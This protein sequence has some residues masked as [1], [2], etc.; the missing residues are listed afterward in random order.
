MNNDDFWGNTNLTNVSIDTENSEEMMPGSHITEFHITKQKE[1]VTTELLNMV[2]NVPEVTCKY[3]ADGGHHNQSDSQSAKSADC[4]LNASKDESFFSNIIGNGDV[5]RV[6]RK[7]LNMME[8][9]ISDILP[10][11]SYLQAPTIVEDSHDTTDGNEMEDL[12][13]TAVNKITTIVWNVPTLYWNPTTSLVP[14]S[15]KKWKNGFTNGL[16]TM[17]YEIVT[18]TRLQNELKW[19]TPTNLPVTLMFSTLPK[20]NITGSPKQK[21]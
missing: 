1:P 11:S 6:I 7:I 10:K 3:G 15:W 14:T 5:A 12:K 20:P 2:S 19:G 8:G 18:P 9:F 4:K 13:H 17:M 21:L 16:T